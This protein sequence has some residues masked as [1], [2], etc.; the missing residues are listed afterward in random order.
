MRSSR[1]VFGAAAA[2]ATIAASFHGAGAAMSKR[3]TF[4]SVVT[5]DP[6]VDAME[7]A[8]AVNPTDPQNLIVTYHFS[9]GQHATREA[10]VPTARQAVAPIMFCGYAVTWDGGR[11]WTHRLTPTVDA[12]AHDPVMTNCSDQLVLFDRHGTAYLT[13]SAY[14]PAFAADEDR[15]IVSHDKGAT[16]S[17]PVTMAGTTFTAGQ[18]PIGHPWLASFDVDRMWLALDDSTGRLYLDG[19]GWWID[20]SAVAH[21]V[22]WMTSSGDGGQTWSPQTV[23]NGPV[24]TGTTQNNPSVAAAFGVAAVAYL[25]PSTPLSPP[26]CTCVELALTTD[27]GRTITHRKTR[28]TSGT[29]PLIAADPTTPRTF[30][31]LVTAPGQ[32]ALDVY[33]THDLGATWSGPAVLGQPPANTR[34]HQWIAY[35]PSGLLGTEWR[36]YY[37]D[38]SY[39]AWAAVS[40]NGGASFA[41][42]VRLSTT[43]SPGPPPPYVAGDDTGTLTMTATTLFGAW[44]DWR[45]G[46]EAEIYWA[47]LPLPR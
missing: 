34:S 25:P 2:M 9:W 44:T 14:N 6:S 15:M 43:K 17:A 28:F 41:P 45:S 16:W 11:R 21:N 30:A 7:P 47:G 42:S 4:E 22:V 32:T 35:S 23:V 38:G 20:T 26:A 27:G 46:K 24:P 8:I 5:S 13:S 29:D 18:S 10:T 19:S 40:T 31:V 39:D 12:P 33:V 3:A 37:G 1:R 36:T